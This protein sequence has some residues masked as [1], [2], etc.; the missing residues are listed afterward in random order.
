M[1]EHVSS[2]DG[3]KV[4]ADPSEPSVSISIDIPTKN[5]DG[6][7]QG[8]AAVGTTQKSGKKQNGETDEEEKKAVRNICDACFCD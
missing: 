3:E 8:D 5:A 4:K 7:T 6:D 2:N 1:G